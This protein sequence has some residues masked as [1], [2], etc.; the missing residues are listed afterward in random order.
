MVFELVTYSD[1]TPN[2]AHKVALEEL[3]KQPGFRKV[4]FGTQVQ[5]PKIGYW[6]VEWAAAEHQA[7]PD[8]SNKEFGIT[9]SMVHVTFTQP[10]GV[11]VS[12]AFEAPVTE[13]TIATLKPGA[14]RETLD[15]MLGGMHH[16]IATTKGA[17]GSAHGIAEE[18]PDQYIFTCGWEAV[19]DHLAALAPEASQA[20]I[21]Q[22]QE[23]VEVD[24]K[25]AKLQLDKLP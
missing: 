20:M 9:K 8:N 10:P 19:E 15:A 4:Y 17:L 11:D 23:L 1:Y 18:N 5:D 2:D 3:A 7:K 6:V 14:S 12:K 21:K 16:V 24:G 25:H 22:L 13:F